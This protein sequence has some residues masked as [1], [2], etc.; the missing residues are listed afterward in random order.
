MQQV[1]IQQ[2]FAVVVLHPP[3]VAQ[4][5]MPLYP[6]PQ[7][8]QRE[9]DSTTL[10]IRNIPNNY[11]TRMVL[12]LLDMTGFEN[13]YDFFYLP[14]DFKR[15]PKHANVGYFFVNFVTHDIAVQALTKL[16]GFNNWPM[17][18]S[19]NKMLS[20]TWATKT[21]GLNGC[22]ERYQNSPIMHQNVPFECK[23]M[24]FHNG[25]A[26]PMAP[27]ADCV[28]VK[29]PRYQQLM[30]VAAASKKCDNED[31]STYSGGGSEDGDKSE[32]DASPCGSI[33]ATS[34]SEVDRD[35]VIPRQA[36][37]MPDEATDTCLKCTTQFT[38]LRRRHHCR[39][40]GLV[41]CAECA[42]RT[43]HGS[44]GHD[45]SYKRVCMDCADGLALAPSCVWSQAPE[46][47]R[48]EI[49]NTF[50]TIPRSSSVERLMHRPVTSFP[51]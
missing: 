39:V 14:H 51:L 50:V 21:Q 27:I 26:T 10:C 4:V 1:G 12:D 6:A 5:Q 20:T 19:S 28:S 17:A 43:R 34:L 41:V 31:A 29:R 15:L 35:V 8:I 18:K 2:G 33:K 24:L 48:F 37:W 49:K 40:C 23:P 36:I 30:K 38:F 47:F 3:F 32:M 7:Q 44:H 42:P 11:T 45:S 22:I 25:E 9:D 46:E 13:S 16:V